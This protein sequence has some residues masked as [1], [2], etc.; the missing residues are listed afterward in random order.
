V[1]GYRLALRAL[2]KEYNFDIMSYGPEFES[3]RQDGNSLFI[4]FSYTGKGL[5]L[6]DTKL[7]GFSLYGYCNK[8]KEECIIYPKQRI[9][10]N[11]SVELILPEDFL[12]SKFKYGWAPYPECNLY[13][14]HGFPAKPFVI[15]LPGNN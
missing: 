12:L 2:E 8:G 7:K 1:I 15:D 13:N 10:S 14:S 6:G 4:S 9:N 3:F 5:V 11:R